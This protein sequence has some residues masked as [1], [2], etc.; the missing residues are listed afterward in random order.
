MPV[1][2]FVIVFAVII[3]L[4]VVFSFAKIDI[5]PTSPVLFVAGFMS[6]FMGILSNMSGPAI[7]LVFQRYSG[8]RLRATIS[9]YFVMS[10]VLAYL[11]LIPA[12][13]L[14]MRELQLSV[15]LIPP[16]LIGFFLSSRLKNVLDRGYT[17]PAVLSLSALS[18]VIV[19]ASR[20]VV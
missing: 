9:G 13:R 11:N 15:Y 16:M 14:G 20:L 6:G 3:L 17:R 19:L 10:L 4:A 1:D 18:A 7:A 8:P 5:N 2:L 12:G